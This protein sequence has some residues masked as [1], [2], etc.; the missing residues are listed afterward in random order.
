MSFHD[1]FFNSIFNVSFSINIVSHI[2]WNQFLQFNFFK[3][4]E[5]PIDGP[6][7]AERGR[8]LQYVG[9][10]FVYS[11]LVQS[12]FFIV[13]IERDIHSYISRHREE[14]RARIWKI[15]LTKGNEERQEKLV[16]GR[17]WTLYNVDTL[18]TWNIGHTKVILIRVYSLIRIRFDFSTN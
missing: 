4:G 17:N 2:N 8:R 6:F 18:I 10:M 13:K 14:T 11:F 12:F 1:K 15:N 9:A 5:K 16:Y 3:F 7:E